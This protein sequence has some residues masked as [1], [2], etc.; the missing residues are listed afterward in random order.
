MAIAFT[1]LLL[2]FGYF[3]SRD[4]FRRISIE[5]QKIPIRWELLVV[6]LAALGSFLG[7]SAITTGSNLAGYS[8]VALWYATGVLAIASAACAFVPPRIALEFVRSTGYAWIY[9][10]IAAIIAGRAVVD[11]TLWHGSVWHPALDLAWKPATDLTFNLVKNLLHLF[12]SNVVADRSSMTIGNSKF[13]VQILPW[14]AGFEGT[15]LMLVFS[16]A[17]L[18]YFRREFRF[19]HALLLIPAGMLV[20]WLSNAVRITALILIGVAGAPPCSSRRL[21]FPSRLDCIQLRGLELCDPDE[22]HALVFIGAARL[23]TVRR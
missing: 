1:S 16:V 6:H 10:L 3:R 11:T 20:I 15:A 23:N 14:C 18:G 21:P 17:W 8:V 9:A 7:L 13:T 5:V 4:S 2:A 22:A 19:P 12:L